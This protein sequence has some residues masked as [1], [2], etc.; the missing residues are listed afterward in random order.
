M[1]QETIKI[2]QAKDHEGLNHDVGS[3]NGKEGNFK[4]NLDELSGN[5][6]QGKVIIIAASTYAGT[7]KEQ[8]L[9]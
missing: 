1:S 9:S 2:I 5:R 7:T 4:K 3:E 8:T 6:E